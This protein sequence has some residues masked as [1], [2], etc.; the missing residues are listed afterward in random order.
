MMRLI[1]IPVFLGIGAFIGVLIG[2]SC[3]P[4]VSADPLPAPCEIVEISW[5]WSTREPMVRI[6]RHH[7][8]V[9]WFVPARYVEAS[10]RMEPHP[11]TGWRSNPFPDRA[12]I[13]VIK[14]P[15]PFWD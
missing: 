11:V 12:K 3:Q 4:N 7:T 2:Y 5:D 10:L 14:L 9:E 1:E 6:R 15:S 13:T 8:G